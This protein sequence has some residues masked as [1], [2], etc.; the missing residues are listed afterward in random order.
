MRVSN[1]IWIFQGKGI[2]VTY[3]LQLNLQRIFFILV[4]YKL[5]L[6]STLSILTEDLC[7]DSQHFENNRVNKSTYTDRTFQ[8]WRKPFLKIEKKIDFFYYYS[9]TSTINIYSQMR[10]YETVDSK[11]LKVFLYKIVTF[12]SFSC[13]QRSREFKNE[14]S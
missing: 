7:I 9:S 1:K 11:S 5:F 2:F 14:V 13:I 8:C 12:R 4:I 6:Q 3:G 10:N